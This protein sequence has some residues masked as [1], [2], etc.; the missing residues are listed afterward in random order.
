M[1][2]K[3]HENGTPGVLDGRIFRLKLFVNENVVCS[4]TGENLFCVGSANS[5]K[6]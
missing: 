6:Y 2:L 3:T 4:G 1:F 5:L